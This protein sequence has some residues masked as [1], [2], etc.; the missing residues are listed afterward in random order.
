M[1]HA[2]DRTLGADS[3]R[4]FTSLA[5]RYKALN[6]AAADDGSL[7]WTGILLEEIYEALSEA[8]AT[9]LRTELVQC[10]AV[11]AAWIEDLDQR[12]ALAGGDG[13]PD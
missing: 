7:D 8:N 4:F 11:I 6:D 10:G 12:E 13:S 9:A 2:H 5:D 3:R 1:D